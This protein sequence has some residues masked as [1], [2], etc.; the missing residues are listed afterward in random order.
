[1]LNIK[2]NLIVE[3]QGMYRIFFLYFFS[4]YYRTDTANHLV[5]DTIIDFLCTPNSW[6]GTG[7]S[8]CRRK[9][10]KEAT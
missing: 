9:I 3:E 10:C 1:M 8:I 7:L 6:K 4:A 5:P 2:Q